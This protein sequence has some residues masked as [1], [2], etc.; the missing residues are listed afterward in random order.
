[1]DAQRDGIGSVKVGNQASVV[2]TV[3]GSTATAANILDLTLLRQAH[4]G[5]GIGPGP[6][7]SSHPQAG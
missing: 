1:V 7:G 4:P 5:F 6:P 2:A 3:S